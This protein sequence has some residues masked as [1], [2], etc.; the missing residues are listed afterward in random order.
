MMF[1]ICVVV[2]CVSLAAV[3]N[4]QQ[5]Q[6]SPGAGELPTPSGTPEPQSA[7]NLLPE[8]KALP[9][10]SPDLRLPS[11]SVLKPGETNA[12]QTEQRA[13]Q[14]SPEEQLKNRVRLSGIRAIAM[15]NPRVIDLLR[16]ANGALTDVAKREFMRAYYHTLCTR[17]RS[18]DPGLN[19]AITDYERTEIRG[20]AQGPSHIEIVSR[21]SQHRDRQRHVRR[22]E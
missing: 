5:A 22:S 10:E 18:L 19:A 3:A 12:A 4:G 16:E 15:R 7:P 13:V 9:A 1:L 2:V 14:L 8:S 11:P 21:A 20:L 6:P 17:M